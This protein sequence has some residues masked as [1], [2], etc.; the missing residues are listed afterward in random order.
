M[1]N[2]IDNSEWPLNTIMVSKKHRVLFTPIAKN[3]C[4]SL[5]RLFVKLSDHPDTERI[6]KQDIHSCLA[7]GGTGLVLSDFS[8]SEATE[9][10]S[11]DSYYHFAVLRNPLERSVSAYL[12]KF[13]VVPPPRGPDGAPVDVAGVVDWVYAQRGEKPDYDRAITYTEFV[14][15]CV[16]SDD[17]HLDTHFRSQQ[18]FLRRQKLDGLFSVE[19][20]ALL[21]PVLESKYGRPVELEHENIR[22][23][24]KILL[25]RARYEQL[26]PG[27]LEKHRPLPQGGVFLTT[28]ISKKLK[29]RFKG[30]I[31]LWESTRGF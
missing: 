9:I 5:K 27:E 13:V 21:K 1:T 10:M 14:E 25:R 6:L 12:N 28:K 8:A 20:M 4:T 24:R 18:S 15:A 7:K 22:K 31:S 19:K 23:K 26:L 30:D 3:A 2:P 11:D 16:N 29:H 17:D